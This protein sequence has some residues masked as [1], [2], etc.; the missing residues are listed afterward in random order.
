MKASKAAKKILSNE[1]LLSLAVLL[2]NHGNITEESKDSFREF[3]RV[4]LGCGTGEFRRNVNKLY[5]SFKEESDNWIKSTND[6]IS[7]LRAYAEGFRYDDSFI[8]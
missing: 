4:L 7:H 5:E 6:L 3:C 1:T 8:R 2:K